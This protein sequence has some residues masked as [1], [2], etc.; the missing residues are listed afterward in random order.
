MSPNRA[1]VVVMLL[2]LMV[3]NVSGILHY[4]LAH[5]YGFELP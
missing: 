5:G 1:Q 3:F 4:F 2:V